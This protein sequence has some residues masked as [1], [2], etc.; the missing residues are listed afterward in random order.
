M[1]FDVKLTIVGN[2]QVGKSCIAKR[3]V[4]D[5]FSNNIISTNGGYFL[6]KSVEVESKKI[7]FQIWDTAGQ[8]KFR[9]LASL[10]YRTALA[11]VVVFDVTRQQTFDDLDFWIH[12]VKTK[13]DKNA[14]IVIVGNKIDA[15]EQVISKEQA[16]VYAYRENLK[17]FET[18]ALTGQGVNEVFAYLAGKCQEKNNFYRDAKVHKSVNLYKGCC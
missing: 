5:E 1:T 15:S 10:Y 6:K 17:Y 8:E 2:T 7:R 3:Y 4:D 16:Q 9:S 14:V 12:E 13:G 11:V 18:S